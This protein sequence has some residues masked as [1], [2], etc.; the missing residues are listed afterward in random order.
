M[1][2][3]F[4][5]FVLFLTSSCI[6]TIVAGTAVTGV[7]MAQDKPVEDTKDDVILTAKIDAEFLQA[8]LKDPRN[9]VGVTVDR[10]RVL[11]TGL[12]ENANIAKVANEI[13]WKVDG[14]KE[15]IDEIQIEPNK[16]RTKNF[17]EYFRDAAITTQL[18]SKALVA[19]D[20][21]SLDVEAV[22][23]NGV[24]YLIGVAKNEDQIRNITDIA[25][26]ISGVKK[27]ISHI[28]LQ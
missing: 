18:N 21:P 4:I 3:F 24:V 16:P 20:V 12:V 8:G 17:V 26:K 23:V 27:V 5:V 10:K 2:K 22:T 6:E 1:K 15:V 13:T 7:V 28:V 11:L 9:K 14:V 19:K 25:A